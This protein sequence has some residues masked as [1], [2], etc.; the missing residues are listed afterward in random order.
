MSCPQ[1]LDRQLL[2]AAALSLLLLEKEATRVFTLKF[3]FWLIA[4]GRPSWGGNGHTNGLADAPFFTSHISVTLL[5]TARHRGPFWSWLFQYTSAHFARLFGLHIIIHLLCELYRARDATKT[6]TAFHV[7]DGVSEWVAWRSWIQMLDSRPAE[8]VL[9]VS[10]FAAGKC[11]YRN[12]SHNRLFP[13]TCQ[14]IIQASPYKMS[15]T[16][17]C[18]SRCTVRIFNPSYAMPWMHL[19]VP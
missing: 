14:F 2:A 18:R 6:N 5:E 11:H 13:L 12:W 15:L 1:Y 9:G 19:R 16:S 4:C 17:Q 10:Q 7:P 3:C 8:S